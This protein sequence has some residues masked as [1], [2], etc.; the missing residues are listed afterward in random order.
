MAR[1]PK[2]DD[3]FS[4]MLPVAASHAGM[5]HNQGPEWLPI[6]KELE[7]RLKKAHKKAI[8]RAQDLIDAT[9]I[10]AVG[11]EAQLKKATERVRQYQASLTELDGQ[12]KAEKEPYRLG[13]AQVDGFFNEPSEELALLKI[14]TE[15]L[16]NAHNDRVRIAERK[17]RAA[18]LAAAA[19]A[20]AEVAR[21]ARVAKEK[22]DAAALKAR[23]KKT[24]ARAAAAAADAEELLDQVDEA[25]ADV[26]RAQRRLAAPAA[27]LTRSRSANAVQSQQEFV[28]FRDLDR[29][30]ISLEALRSHIGIDHLAQA[31]RS[32]VAANNDALKEDLKNRRQPLAGVEFFLNSR[33]RVG[34]G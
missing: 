11:N 5:G 26:T 13:G 18:D 25:K 21:K 1:D 29:N 12:R 20:Q 32:Y 6:G 17:K 3:G 31:V 7:D 34:G 22:A 4:E 9:P 27:E 19:L 8:A 2:F 15:R 23:G 30:K 14:A 28:D 16:M 33:T 10:A 24:I